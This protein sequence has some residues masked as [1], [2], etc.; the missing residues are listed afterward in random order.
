MSAFYQAYFGTNQYNLANVP[1]TCA[2]ARVGAPAQG[3]DRPE[4]QRV[5]AL[6]LLLA[7]RPTTPAGWPV[8]F[9]RPED[10]DSSSAAMPSGPPSF[11]AIGQTAAPRPSPGSR[12]PIQGSR[13]S[14]CDS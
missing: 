10:A 2:G 9:S 4:W 5:I 1:K 8:R 3:R 6:A 11:P 7:P 13:S 14:P 12:T